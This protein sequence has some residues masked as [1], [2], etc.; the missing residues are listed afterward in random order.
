MK[1]VGFTTPSTFPTT[2]RPIR[3]HPVAVVSRKNIPIA[4][5]AL[6]AAVTAIISKHPGEKGLIHTVSYDLNN[7]LLKTISTRNRNIYSYSSSS[8]KDNSVRNFRKN[9]SGAVILAPSLDRGIDL[10]NDECRYIVICKLPFP[11]LGTKQVSARLHTKGGQ[12]W[13]NVKTVRSLV[14]M[15]GRGMRAHDDYCT[16]YILD[17]QFLDI[18]WRRS[19]N[20]LPQWWKDALVWNAG[21]L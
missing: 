16:S 21:P 1:W 12:L 6:T 3:I 19:K 17:K 8:E 10:P 14:Q 15:T 4:Y 18:I 13:Y 5:P 20:L 9:P 2:R 11:N 7:H